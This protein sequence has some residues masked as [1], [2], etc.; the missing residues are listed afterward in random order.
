MVGRLNMETDIYDLVVLLWEI[1]DSKNFAQAAE[2]RANENFL[3]IW[4]I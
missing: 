2:H 3:G 4:Q 1:V